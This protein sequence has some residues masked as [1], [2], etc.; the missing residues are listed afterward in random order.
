M[1]GDSG[2]VLIVRIIK[3]FLRNIDWSFLALDE[4]ATYI[5]TDDTNAKQLHAT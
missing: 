4:G 5:F 1:F 3:D 2:F